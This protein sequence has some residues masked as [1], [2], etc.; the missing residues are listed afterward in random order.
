MSTL[1]T[2]RGVLAAGSLGLLAGLAPWQLARAKDIVA[3][4]PDISDTTLSLVDPQYR[5]FAQS[6][7]GLELTDQT[8]PAIRDMVDSQPAP[9]TPNPPAELFDMT[10]SPA[11]FFLLRPDSPVA[12]PA[13]AIVYIHGGGYIF[14]TAE[15][16]NSYCHDLAQK[17]GALV[18]NVDYRFAPETPFPGPV[19]DC[20]DVLSYV[21]QNAAALGVD[22][23]R[24]SIMGHSAGGGLCAALA[25]LARDR[26]EVPVKAQFPIYPML[27][28]RTGTT[29]AP[30][31]N[32]TT[33]EFIWTRQ[34]NRYGW[35][36]LRG[37][38]A[39][40]DD[41]IGHF[42][43]SLAPSLAGLPPTFTIVGA[44][45]LFLEEDA[46]Y[47]LRL[48]RD[49]V[50]VEFTIYPGAVHGFDLISGTTLSA[51]FELD[52]LAALERLL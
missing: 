10:D 35:D 27:D 7:G 40:D 11:R 42:S 50:P 33:G 15:A 31:N 51:R 37:T 49:R 23:A 6:M 34:A 43:P 47:A 18:F 44:L 21:F 41:R 30:V 25:V 19:E 29:E 32:L 14:G 22:P 39:L 52:L 46:A 26:G 2:R 5:E 24:I 17:S 9:G 3:A 48:T 1:P 28:Y 12:N 45:D 20:H 36:S 4:A 8:L 16:Y 38:Y 13:P